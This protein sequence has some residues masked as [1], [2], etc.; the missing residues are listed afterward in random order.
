MSCL[1]NTQLTLSTNPLHCSNFFKKNVYGDT[2]S[3]KSSSGRIAQEAYSLM[4]PLNCAHGFSKSSDGRKI[5]K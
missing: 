1:C 3:F 5:K 2:P 4:T